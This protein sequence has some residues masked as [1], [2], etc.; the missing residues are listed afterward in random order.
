MN[1]VDPVRLG[2]LIGEGEGCQ[3][4][5]EKGQLAISH[6]PT[7]PAPM[8]SPFRLFLLSNTVMIKSPGFAL[9]QH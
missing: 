4:K 2:Y 3:A 7:G 5:L 6:R 9:P 1:H 8:A